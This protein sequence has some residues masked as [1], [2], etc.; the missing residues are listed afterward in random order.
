[1]AKQYF[2]I[3]FD[4]TFVKVE[5]LDVL[6]EI[7]LDGTPQKDEKVK[8]II[9]ITNQGMNGDIS[10]AESL[11]K[12]LAIL[13]ANKT[14]IASLIS[15]LKKQISKSVI[16]NKNFFETH[17]DEIY[18]VSSGFAEFIIP[19]VADYGIAASHVLANTF[20]FD[21][22]GNITGADKNNPLAGDGGK[23]TVVKNLNLDGDVSAIGDGYT[24]YEIKK[25][26]LAQ[27][28]FA[29]TEN[30]SREKVIAVADYI[31]PSFDEFLYIKGLPM[32]TSFPKNRIKVLLLENVHPDALALFKE[33]G[34]NVEFEKGAL[35]E[36]ELCERIKDVHIL[37]LRSKTNLTA[38]VLENAN[39]LMA[40]GA[41]CIGTNQIDLAECTKLGI[42]VFNAPYSN[43][44]SVVELAIGEIIILM[45]GIAD[46]NLQMH[47]GIWNKS[48]N[49]CFE[50][51][52]KKLGII[53]YGNIGAQLS[54]VA[55][56]IGLQVYF[57]D[58]VDKLAL[59]NAKKC[60]SIEELLNKVDIVSLHIDG[61][62][63]N[64][65]YFTKEHFDMM[66]QGSI[67]LNLARGPVVDIDALRE[68]ILSGKIIGAGVDVFPEEPKTNSDP[69]VSPLIGLPNTILSPHI[70]GSTD[71]AQQHIGN[72]VPTKLIGYM[73]E[74]NTYGSVNFPNLQLPELHNAHRLLHIHRNTSGVLAQINNILTK[75]DCNI[76]GQYLK[77]NET[78]GY[79]IT[80]VDKKHSNEAIEELKQIN[81]TIKVRIL[82]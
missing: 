54:V 55:E 56:A 22:K 71:E 74:G 37:G 69:F 72:Y 25:S 77:T 76:E 66:K 30:V 23:I 52:N 50:V 13:T 62:K 27:T 47:K 12:R 28:F 70:G 20:T 67:F 38:K 79:V 58:V 9:S 14:H 10:F 16:R 39:R 35:D 60:D 2:I 3:D 61:R 31:T 29:Y 75:Y 49:N 57:Y 73:N 19:V 36:D 63:S 21:E 4:S 68:N 24:D 65:G 53:G 81:G 26:G 43:T 78:I 59:G 15:R 80:D 8:E 11:N 51:R 48:A 1:M 6:A 18:I 82:Y 40:V 33:E 45:R 42:A 34:F 46:K 17:A 7:A 5:S 64:T 41:F 44:R 32:K